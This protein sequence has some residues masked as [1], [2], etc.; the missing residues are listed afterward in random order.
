MFFFKREKGVLKKTALA[1]LVLLFTA[2]LLF[3]SCTN[4]MGEKNDPPVVVPIAVPAGL[5]GTWLSNNGER[6]T[7]T[8][9]ALD[10][11]MPPFGIYGGTIV[12]HR[13]AGSGAGY[14]TIKVDRNDFSPEA[15]GTYYVLHYKNLG[16]SAMEIS[17][18]L[19]D[20]LITTRQEAEATYMTGNA[21]NYFLRYSPVVTL[22]TSEKTPEKLRGTWVGETIN[23]MTYTFEITEDTIVLTSLMEMWGMEFPSNHFT[24][25]VQNVRTGVYGPGTGYMT[26]N[27]AVVQAHAHQGRYGILHWREYTENGQTMVQITVS[28]SSAAGW[29]NQSRAT[30]EEAEAEADFFWV[31]DIAVSGGGFLSNAGQDPTGSPFAGNQAAT[32]ITFTRQ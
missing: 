19:P 4:P 16:A 6:V 32:L 18:A 11:E 15:P 30:P 12:N 25:A 21:P 5:Q 28:T 2:G 9:A 20:M 27:F 13:T 7:I 14:I 23:D 31:A 17:G 24:A 1:A 26:L 29:A 10:Y 22:A 8:A 3:L